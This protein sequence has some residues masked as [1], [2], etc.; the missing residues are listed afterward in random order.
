MI[1]VVNPNDYSIV[2][3]LRLEDASKYKLAFIER[4]GDTIIAISKDYFKIPELQ[5]YATLK[6]K[7]YIKLTII[8]YQE[9]IIN[10]SRR[11]R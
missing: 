7:E 1:K 2:K 11:Q 10:E 5:Q 8:R 9:I 6:E 4:F 3:P